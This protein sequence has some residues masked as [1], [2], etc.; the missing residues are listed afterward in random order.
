MKKLYNLLF[1]FAFL[2]ITTSCYKGNFQDKNQKYTIEQFM[3][4]TQ[5]FGSDF[6]ADEKSVLITSKESGVL[7][8]Y[9]INIETG[10]QTQL[11]HSSENAIIARS[12]FPL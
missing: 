4:S 1:S 2:T 8:A 3:N 9:S 7:N 11:T 5:I 6:S 12:F 10:E